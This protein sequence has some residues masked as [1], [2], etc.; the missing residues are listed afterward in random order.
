MQAIHWSFPWSEP[1]VFNSQ[2]TTT[3]TAATIGGSTASFNVT[4]S[5]PIGLDLDAMEATQILVTGPNGYSQSAVLQ[6]VLGSS[7]TSATLSF[8]ANSPGSQWMGN[9][10]GTYTISTMAS[11]SPVAIG[12]FT[13]AVTRIDG[14]GNT[15]KTAQNLGKVAPG[16]DTTIADSVGPFDPF[17]Y[18]RIQVTKKAGLTLSVSGLIDNVQVQLLNAAGHMINSQSAGSGQSTLYQNIIAPGIYYIEL[19]GNGSLGTDYSMNLTSTTLPVDKAGNTLAASRNLGQ[20]GSKSNVNIS[21]SLDPF[22]TQDDYHF[23]VAKNVIPSFSFSGLA[24][25]ATVQLLSRGGS[26]VADL[27]VDSSGNASYSGPLTPGLYY[28]NAI[29]TSQTPSNYTL[30]LGATA[31]AAAKPAT[32]HVVAAAHPSFLF[33]DTTVADTIFE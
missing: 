30:H 19:N 1:V 9:D 6:N 14:A 20:L 8:L 5:D 2:L 12:S 26:V 13:I 18:Y 27:P 24:D 28:I 33:S 21:N 7:A 17:D 22:N 15:L 11:G 31:T 29:S 16:F 3:A 10:N 23:T 4:F 32:K 25:G